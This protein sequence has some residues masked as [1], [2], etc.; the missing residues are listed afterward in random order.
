MT[1]FRCR[2]GRQRGAPGQGAR[3]RRNI[4]NAIK[5]KQLLADQDLSYE[6][7]VFHGSAAAVAAAAAEAEAVAAEAEAAEAEATEVAEAKARGAAT[8]NSTPQRS[9]VAPA[10]APAPSL[11]AA[12]RASRR[13]RIEMPNTNT[14]EPTAREPV[15]EGDAASL[16]CR[17][18]CPGS[19]SSC[20]SQRR[21][22]E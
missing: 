12:G 14:L 20:C 17:E 9:A 8:A 1:R 15:G 7:A 22:Q 11:P 3:Q 18:S 16:S 13:L 2:P 21:F 4:A 19:P 6:A 5:H 10:S